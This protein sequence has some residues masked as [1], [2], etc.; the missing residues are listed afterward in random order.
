[1]PKSAASP[2]ILFNIDRLYLRRA[3]RGVF[4]CPF[5]RYWMTFARLCACSCGVDIAA[6][7]GRPI[8]SD[9][10]RKGRLWR[11]GTGKSGGKGGIL[12]SRTIVVFARLALCE[13]SSAAIFD[14][15]RAFLRVRVVFCVRASSAWRRPRCRET[16]VSRLEGWRPCRCRRF[17]LAPVHCGALIFYKPAMRCIGRGRSCASRRPGRSG[18]PLRRSARRSARRV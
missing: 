8:F 7:A 3:Q 10:Y 4:V 11:S 5:F 12:Q 2:S 17:S 9:F 16:F 6:N 15:F 18:R 13:R 1:M 14:F